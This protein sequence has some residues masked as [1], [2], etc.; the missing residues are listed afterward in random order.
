MNTIVNIILI[1]ITLCILADVG[2]LAVKNRQLTEMGMTTAY[3]RKA[4]I[5]YAIALAAVVAIKFLVV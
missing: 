4:L 5:I 1:L 3:K 2:F